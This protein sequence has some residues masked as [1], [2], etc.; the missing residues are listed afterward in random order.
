MG[1]ETWTVI[2]ECAFWGAAGVILYTYVAYPMWI[3]LR[4]RFRPHSWRKAAFEPSVTVIMAVHDG[5]DR[6]REKIDHL[7]SLDYPPGIT[8]LIVVSDGSAAR[9]EAVLKELVHPRLQA[10]LCREHRGKAAAI[11]EGIR[12]ATG[13][14]L[15]FT[16]L[17]QRLEPEA[18]RSLVSNF[19]DPQVGCA[20]G[21]LCLRTANKE[22]IT[23]A[24]G[25][26]YWRYEQGIRTCEGRVDSVLG[27]SGALYAIRRELATELPQ[28]LILDDM[29]QPLSVIRQG[30][31]AVLDTSARFWDSLPETSAGEFQRKVR[32]LAG[33]Y[34]LLRLAPWVLSRENR[35]RFRLFSHKLLRLVVPLLLITTLLTSCLLRHT[36]LY[37]GMALAQICFWALAALGPL[38]L[39][40]VRRVASPVAAFCLLNAAA[41]VA[42]VKFVFHREPLWK[43]WSPG[44]SEVTKDAAVSGASGGEERKWVTT[45]A[46]GDQH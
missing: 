41:A 5:A 39:P 32:T 21:E 17:R 20:A 40:L 34:Q 44:N 6:L 10:I 26:L 8:D 15:V 46:A 22:S 23:G 4:S 24:I 36:S 35:L 3:Y 30:Y 13:A 19:A 31:R 25:G 18:I 33:N 7:L 29:Y 28:G 2:L 1:R 14:I 45:V 11:N 12:R 38:H 16:D 27:V 9:T 43:M 42:L 37:L